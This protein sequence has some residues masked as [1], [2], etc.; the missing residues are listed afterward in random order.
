MDGSKRLNPDLVRVITEPVSD[1]AHSVGRFEIAE[2]KGI[3]TISN[4]LGKLAT[5]NIGRL[6]M[7]LDL[8]HSSRGMEKIVRKCQGVSGPSQ[9]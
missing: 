9:F 5:I 8:D 1:V 2:S 4:E 3:A 6:G 7:L